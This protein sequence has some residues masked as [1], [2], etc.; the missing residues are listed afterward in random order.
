MRALISVYDKTGLVDFAKALVE[1]GW[2]LVSTGGSAAILEAAGLPVVTVES[3]TGFPEMLDGRVKT[4]HPHVH[5][6]LLA[7]RDVPDHMDTLRD[8][9]IIPI[10]MLVSNLYPFEHSVQDASLDDLGKIEQID[11]GGPAMVRAASKNHA[12]V[13]VV[14]DPGDYEGILEALGNG[15][16]D[17]SV[18]RKLAAKA[19]GHVS[20]YDALVAEFLRGPDER[21]PDELAIPLRR[22]AIP[23]Y[24]ENPQQPAAV[25]T[26]LSTNG[27]ER[28]ILRAVSLK[29]EPLSF[30]NYLDTDA[31]WQASKL[32]DRP[33]VC[34]VK[35]MVPCGLATRDTIADAYAAALDGD[36]VSAFGGVVSLNR[37]VDLAAAELM[38]K[39]K[40][41]IIVAPDFDDDALAILQRKKGTRI[42]SMP[43]EEHASSQATA[44]DVRPIA[45]GMLVQVPDRN[46]DDPSTWRVVTATRPS[47]EQM[48]DLE[49]AWQAVRLVKS[50]AI[51]VARDVAI[52]GVGAGQPNRVESVN[53]ATKKAGEKARGAALASDA[54]FPFGDSIELAASFGI[55]TVIQPGGSVKDDEVIA[56]ADAAGIAM[57]FTGTR[58]FRH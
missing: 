11:I 17:A 27:T 21:F 7:R 48:R 43:C 40:L 39:L 34:I 31:A 51:V 10:D 33:A 19:F 50:N 45:G 28:G 3:V 35:H 44:L 54:F 29:G 14:V 25:Y 36:P 53:L 4:L 13:T 15:N 49:F 22:A 26:R 52:A 18:R 5:G 42:L 12:A 57:V 2:E 58:H 20:T 55:A 1:L 23:K 41:D 24:G 8:H 46:P 30:N 9:G 16:I 47:D 56:A 37:R 38:R 32:F 6:A